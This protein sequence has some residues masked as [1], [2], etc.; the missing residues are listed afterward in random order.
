MGC[1]S[2]RMWLSDGL[3]GGARIEHLLRGGCG[4]EGGLTGECTVDVSL[5]GGYARAEASLRGRCG[6]ICSIGESDYLIVEPNDI[7]WLT[8]D[9]DFAQELAVYSNV[10]WS[11]E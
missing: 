9:N 5:R 1:L 4:F 10:N 3:A 2:G 8:P 7:V 11:V 6:I